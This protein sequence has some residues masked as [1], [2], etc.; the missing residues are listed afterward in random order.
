MAIVVVCDFDNLDPWINALKKVD[1]STE[2][3]RIEEVE[4]KSSVEFVLAWNY[5]HGL[6]RDYPGV[7]T[8]S[9]MGAGVD[10]LINDPF[11]PKHINIVRIVDPRLSQ[12][13]YEFALAVIM[14]RLRQLTN[15]RE[16]QMKGIWKKKRYLH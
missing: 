14:N 1:P 7:K 10:H 4:D 13:M 15:F 16:N 3:I 6:F 8:I 5:P 12:D 11:L 2:I 9:S